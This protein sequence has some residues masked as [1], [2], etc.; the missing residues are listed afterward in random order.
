MPDPR[1]LRHK[2]EDK[3]DSDRITA[4]KHG[5][6]ESVWWGWYWVETMVDGNK[7]YGMLCIFHIDMYI[8]C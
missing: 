6:Q 2:S 7:G 3:K 8:H 4:S 5:L 1:D